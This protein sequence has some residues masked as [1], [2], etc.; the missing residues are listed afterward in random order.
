MLAHRIRRP[1]DDD[2][3]IFVDLTFETATRAAAF[4]TFLEETVW[5]SRDASPALAGAPVA[6]ILTDVEVVA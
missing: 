5:P 4:H 1:V 2:T 3:Y 6:R